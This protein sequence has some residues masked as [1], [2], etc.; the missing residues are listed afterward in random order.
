M[1]RSLRFRTCSALLVSSLSLALSPPALAQFPFKFTLGR[2]NPKASEPSGNSVVQNVQGVQDRHGGKH[3]AATAPNS[4]ST[5]EMRNVF[6][7]EPRLGM[8]GTRSKVT[9]PPKVVEKPKVTE[10]RREVEAPLLAETPHFAEPLPLPPSETTNELKPS[11]SE[12]PPSPQTSKLAQVP[13]NDAG[14]DVQLRGIDPAAPSLNAPSP[15]SPASNSTQAIQENAPPADLSPVTVKSA[16]MLGRYLQHIARRHGLQPPAPTDITRAQLGQYFLKLM[17]QLANV[18]ADQLSRQDLNDIGMLTD[19]FED[20]LWQV[21]GTMALRAFKAPLAESEAMSKKMA[22]AQ[23]RLAA[24]EKLKINGDFTFV[25]QSDMGRGDRD[26][27]TANLRA[28]INFLA[29]VHEAKA[30]DRLGDGY[31]FARLTAAAGRFFPRNK[32][33]LSPFN[34]VVDANASPFNSG[35]NEVQ[36]AS[37]F[38]NNNNSNSLRPTVSLEQAY[39]S[40]DVRLTNKLKG[41]YKA[42]LIY[43]GAMFDNNNF[44]NNESLQFLSTQFVNSISWRPNFNGPAFV[45]SVERPI[46]RGKAFVR[47]TSGIATISNRDV[48]G[49][50]GFNYE[51]QVGHTFFNKEGNLRAGFWNWN[52][53]RGTQRPFTTPID[54]TGT[55]LLSL[56]PGGTAQDGPKPVGMYANFDQRIWKNIGIFGRY[57]MNDRSIGE[58]FLGGLLSSRQSWSFGA[59][60]PI[61]SFYA[62]RT[63]DVLGLA[64]GHVYGYSRGNVISP[65]T[66]AFLGLN[67]EIPTD[68]EGVN[69]NLA[70][71]NPGARFRRPEKTLEVYYRY[72]LN[73]NVSISPDFQYIWHPGGTAPQP[74]IIVLSTRLNVVF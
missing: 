21:K 6:P 22:D 36:T 39:Y 15:V 59:E 68:L 16:E 67:G 53:R 74:G 44:A 62:K 43:L 25:P 4:D 55:G 17:P 13:Q 10:T 14:S 56:I 35:P 49:S 2:P 23:S 51:A 27:M 65:A 3:A 47:A 33:L 50:Y 69:A 64:Y 9:E 12:L 71:M 57:A 31:L 32:Y 24:I 58:V 20:A 60:V 28:R 66:P 73:K 70:A 46:L 48:F 1:N 30:E 52:F 41:N 63:D 72:Q 38:I 34:D 19:E 7:Q 11:P 54:L 29:R 26:S 8:L 61:K 42:G 5:I 40:Q 45:A 37:L 18:P